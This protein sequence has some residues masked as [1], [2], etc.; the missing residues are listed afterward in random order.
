VITGDIIAQK[1][2]HH[3]LA[4]ITWEKCS[5]RKWLNSEFICSLP[6]VIRNNVIEVVNQNPNN[7][8][9]GTPGGGATRD[10]VFLLNL[11]ELVCYFGDSGELR[12]GEQFREEILRKW[13]Q[14]GIG[15]TRQFSDQFDFNRMARYNY[16]DDNGE[17]LYD[18][19]HW[20]WLRSPGRDPN[21]AAAVGNQGGVTLAGASVY[22][23]EADVFVG[24]GGVR[25]ALW[26]NL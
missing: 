11:D 16:V 13:Y 8:W 24:Y 9:F 4:D 20:W 1:P 2:Y 14:W 15:D 23:D 18:I 17:Y 6:L 19:D 26:L 25:P 3:V 22:I 10:K 12:R 5:L 21:Y 7:P